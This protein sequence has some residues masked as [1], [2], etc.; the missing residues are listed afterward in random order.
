MGMKVTKL[1]GPSYK[2]IYIRC[3]GC[4]CLIFRKVPI[5]AKEGEDTCRKCGTFL[6]WEEIEDTKKGG[7]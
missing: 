5:K 4:G 6:K 1:S 2:E 3:P 7:D